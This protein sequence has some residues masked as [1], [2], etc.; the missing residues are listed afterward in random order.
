MVFAFQILLS[1][2]SAPVAWQ[3]LISTSFLDVA[4][5][6]MVAPRYLNIVTCFTGFPSILIFIS[7]LPL[8]PPAT[9]TLL[10]S[11]LISMPYFFDVMLSL[12]VIYCSSSSPSASKSMSSANLKFGNFIPPHLIPP[13]NPSSVSSMIL[14]RKTLNRIGERMQPYL[15]PTLVLNHSLNWPLPVMT[16]VTAFS[17]KSLINSVKCFPILNFF[18]VCH[19]ALCQTRSKAFWNRWNKEHISLAVSNFF[20][21][22]ISDVDDLFSSASVSSEPSL[23]LVKHF[24]YSRLYTSLYYLE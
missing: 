9:I 7:F 14:S 24:F 11:L 17:Y 8:Q 21:N 19:K 16:F 15:T 6:V 3:I 12:F 4:S 10:F 20:F 5:S 13:S 1:L 18:I 22:D 23:A 2:A